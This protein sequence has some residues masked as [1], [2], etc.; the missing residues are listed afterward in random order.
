MSATAR[1]E[2]EKVNTWVLTFRK[3][4]PVTSGRA[5]SSNIF[6]LESIIAVR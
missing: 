3:E 4:S 6:S 5:W 1:F 2:R